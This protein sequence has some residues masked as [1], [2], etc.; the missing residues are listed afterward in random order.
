M[1]IPDGDQKISIVITKCIDEI[2]LNP[3]LFMKKHPRLS[4]EKGFALVVCLSL[5]ILLTVVAV[6][7]LSLAT[8]S[9]RSSTQNEAMATAK[10]NARLALML[11]IGDLQKSLGP[12]KAISA[13]S[14]ILS[15]TPGKPN[16]AGVWES[17]DFNPS[18]G[19]LGYTDEKKTRFRRWLVSAPDP[20]TAEERDFVNSAW[21]GQ[22]VELVGKNAL[23]GLDTDADKVRA[24]KVPLSKNNKK[25]G[26]YAWHVSDESQKARINLYRDPSRNG[27]LAK[28]RA[29]LAGHRPDPTFIKHGSTTL[30]FLP[31]DLT[32]ND[33]ENA[34]ASSEKVTDIDQVDL[35][36]STSKI[37]QFRNDVTPYSL[38]LLTDVRNGGLKKDLSSIFEMTTSATSVILPNDYKN[39]KL[40][41]STHG[42]T[43]VSD[44]NWSALASYYNTFRSITLFPDTN[45]TFYQRPTVN[46]PMPTPPALPAPPTNFYPGPVIAKVEAL[47]TFV[48]RDA[49]ANWVGT[50]GGVDPAIK[51]MGHLMYTP[52][53]TLHNPYNINLQFDNLEVTIR[54]VPV[55]FNF[56]ANN[57]PQCK[58]LVSLNEM[59]VYDSDK[60]EKT[61][62]M[63]I[64]NWSAPASTSTTGPIVMKPGQTMVCGPYLHPGASFNNSMGTYFFDWQNNLTGTGSLPIN[65]KPGFAG[66]CFGYDIDWT[67]PPHLSSGQQ[68][69][70][71]PG[72]GV[73]G[74]RATD[75]VHM[76]Y[77]IRQ[78][79]R[80]LNTA[81][82]VTAKLTSQGRT[83]DYGGLS[84]QYQDDATLKKYFSKTYRYPTTGEFNAMDAYANN[85]DPI[86]SHALAKTVGIFSA[87]ARTTSGGVYETGK[88][89]ETPGAVNSLLDGRL[90]GK[91]FMFHNP[92]RTV[93]RMDMKTEKPGAHSHEL[94]FQWLPGNVDNVFTID[95]TNRTP[96]LTGNT[97]NRGIKSGSYLEI[98]SGPLQTIADFRRSNALTSSYLPN[99]VQPVANSV[100]SPMM[101]TDKV[102]ETDNSVASYQLLDH[103]VLA[104]HALYDR[105][106][107][108][109]FATDG[110]V[111]PD[112]VFENFMAGT[113]PLALQAF[114][115]YLPSGKT[116]KAAK[117]ELFSGGKPVDTAFQRAAE[118]QM[119]RGSF[120]VNSTN[121]QAWKA[122]LASMNTSEIVTLWAKNASL[123]VKKSTG[124]PVMAMS[125]MN[126]GS[127]GSPGVDPSRVDDGR[128]NEWNGYRELTDKEIETLATEIVKQVRT[129]GPFL[130]M[131][132]FVNRRIGSD[133]DLT[134]MGALEE[135]IVESKLNDNVFT[136]QIPI[137]QTD[138]SDPNLYNYKTV[139]STTGNPAAG[140]P[141]WIN[142]GDLMRIIEP[143]ATVRS[144][145]FVVR[146]CGEAWDAAGKVI[147][148][149]YA[150]AVVQRI[151]EYIDPVDRPSFNVYTESGG[152]K[153]NKDFGRR[154][155]LVS[156]RWLS[157]K[158]V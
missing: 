145:T 92:A 102:V 119:V 75:T 143:T 16:T 155:S 99:F 59:F 67:T 56:Y 93:V 48:T 80:G 121:I 7:L 55:A 65:A 53:V 64:A 112:N 103:S 84:F 30:D 105:F 91:P 22:T 46:V 126:G 144:D 87:Y 11:A 43:G 107:F 149:A 37:K 4:R 5:M 134:R 116:S 31:S 20:K 110:K 57:K 62:V 122:L 117:D 158:E 148:K 100:I 85:N 101:S 153:V 2:R 24:G 45:P 113:S 21:T 106:Y 29:L 141:G 129:R 98:P 88:R 131:S 77:A 8:I 108:S 151:P 69:D 49:H 128:T 28:K 152:A 123:E 127:V 89:T 111:T 114:E 38:G 74:L 130:S 150:E 83:F 41:Q 39:K 12:D 138:V 54:N 136:T 132:E 3:N 42:I 133:S 96:Y 61:F 35:L 82:E 40:Y 120:N 156:F 15:A 66:R 78:P 73:F 71:N 14:E 13:N 157:L 115:P 32:F 9:L 95:T 26:A 72:A 19:S 27:T 47:F 104:N 52:L 36:S 97:T 76:D 33:F 86:S 81:F 6:G 146:V 135:A 68:S 60:R 25:L 90:A 109:T 140:A 1:Q 125:L 94:N 34:D 18:S 10:S 124:I 118:Y 17:W 79:T 58:D 142:Q 44:P 63:K 137:T 51:Y 147:A 50:L 154:M 139:L 23:G 70:G